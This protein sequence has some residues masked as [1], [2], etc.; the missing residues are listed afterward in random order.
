M[1]NEQQKIIDEVY[2]NYC[3]SFENQSIIEQNSYDTEPIT[4]QMFIDKVKKLDWFSEKWG[5]KIEER[6]LSL[7]ERVNVFN[8]KMENE[9]IRSRIATLGVDENYWESSLEKTKHNIPTKLKKIIYKNNTI[10]S[11]E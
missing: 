11:Y 10:E 6:E 7:E 9:G 4:K 1:N 3:K 8:L 5:L 2:E